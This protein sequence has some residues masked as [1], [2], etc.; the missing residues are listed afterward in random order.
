MFFSHSFTNALALTH[1]R[2]HTMSAKRKALEFIRLTS[3]TKALKDLA[4]EIK[5]R[6]CAVF[7]DKELERVKEEVMTFGF[8]CSVWGFMR[9]EL[10][11]LIEWYE[12]PVHAWFRQVGMAAEEDPEFDCMH[13]TTDELVSCFGCQCDLAKEEE[14]VQVDHG[15]ELP[16]YSVE[17]GIRHYDYEARHC[18]YVMKKD[19][20]EPIPRDKLIALWTKDEELAIGKMDEKEVFHEKALL[21]S[22]GDTQIRSGVYKP[23][24]YKIDRRNVLT[25]FQPC[26]SQIRYRL[27]DAE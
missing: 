10:S 14:F 13:S 9:D 20:T 27:E 18:L 7:R 25:W 11:E 12:V 6:Q 26:P 19:A 1:P 22:G 15:T 4:S 21:H 23:R 2:T 24:S 17:R 16:E 8:S 3:D 5:D